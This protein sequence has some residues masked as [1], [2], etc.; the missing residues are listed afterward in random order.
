MKPLPLLAAAALCAAAPALAH[1]PYLVP[2]DFA[3]RAGQT[4]A[5]DAAFAEAFFVPEAAFDDSRFEVTLPDGRTAALAAQTMKTR[6]VAEYTLP[7]GTGTYRLG[8]GPR[9][10]ARFRT[11]EIGG[12]REN[13]RDPA[14]KVPDGATVVS[15]FQSLTRAE[16]YVSVGAPDRAALAPRNRG[17]ELVAVSHPDDL[18]VGETFEFVVQYDGR[19]L[20]AQAL[21]VTEAVWS[22]DRTP[23]VVEL[24]TDAAGHARLP[25][26]QAG[27]WVALTRYRS[28]APAGAAA[29]EYSHSYTLTFRVLNP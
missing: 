17:L 4:V 24:R 5:L 7:P 21:T 12:K 9:L 16:T 13:S 3:P 1:T 28:P 10:G 22:S 11:W 29:P 27:T 15:D 23:Q 26:K 18:Y 19:P 6:T 14:A 8:T 25:L 20:P 2:S